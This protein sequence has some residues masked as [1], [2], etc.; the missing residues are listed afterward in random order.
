MPD[1]R[2]DFI[3]PARIEITGPISNVLGKAVVEFGIGI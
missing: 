3:I 1:R 2:Q